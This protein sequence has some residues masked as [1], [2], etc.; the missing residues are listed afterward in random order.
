MKE[1]KKY[2]IWLRGSSLVGHVRASSKTKAMEKAREMI[3][4]NFQLKRLPAGTCVCPISEDY[5]GHIAKLNRE[6]GFS[7]MT[8]F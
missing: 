8:D 3:L 5:Y 6:A 2:Q 7:A 4:N 1:D